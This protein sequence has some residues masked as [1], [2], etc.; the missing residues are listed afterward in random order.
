MSKI[1]E[2]KALKI[3]KQYDYPWDTGSIFKGYVQGYDQA[4]QDLLE[5]ACEWLMHNNDWH[6][7]EVDFYVKNFKNYMQNESEN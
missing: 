4:M 3:V 1:A 2:Q 6:D 5:K 7:G